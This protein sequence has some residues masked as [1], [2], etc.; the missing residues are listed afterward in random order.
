MAIESAIGRLLRR[1]RAG[2]VHLAWNEPKLS[3]APETISL[4][5]AAF[6]DNASIPARYAGVGVGD[7]LSPPLAWSIVPSETKELMLIMQDPDAP[8][9]KPVVHLI[10]TGIPMNVS[11]VAEGGL[12]PGANPQF[13]FG[14]G[15]FGR[16]GYMGPRPVRGHGPHR[17]I[18]QIFAL[19]ETL[20]I[21]E[22][23]DF[24]AIMARI[25]RP[26]LARGRLVGTFERS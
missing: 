13:H 1:V 9:P 14:R 21:S 24:K 25:S 12:T 3:D 26:I 2:D 18:F 11:S 19:A 17:Y 10:V 15:S 20:G 23:P 16:I 8:L 7:N 6:A 5:S 22:K 4:T